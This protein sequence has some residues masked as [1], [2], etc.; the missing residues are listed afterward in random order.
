LGGD[1]LTRL[2]NL[3]KASAVTC[4]L[5]IYLKTRV[6][7][8]EQSISLASSL[9]FSSIFKIIL[10]VNCDTEATGKK[11]KE[12][13]LQKKQKPFNQTAIRKLTSVTE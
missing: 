1:I 4:V 3:P 6:V 10:N 7:S 2:T 8:A 5:S 11:K 12:K 13:C 9:K